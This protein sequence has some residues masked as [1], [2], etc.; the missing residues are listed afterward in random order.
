[1]SKIDLSYRDRHALKWHLNGITSKGREDDRKLDRLWDALKL[2]VVTTKPNVDSDTLDVT[3]ATYELTKA[4]RDDLI[5][6]LNTPKMGAMSRLV[7]DIDRRLLKARDGG[8][9]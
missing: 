6:W 9:E 7:H 4:E 8:E 2:D 5:D 1:M 3:P